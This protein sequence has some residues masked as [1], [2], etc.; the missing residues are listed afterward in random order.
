M[1]WPIWAIC[2]GPG[3]LRG[4]TDHSRNW[5]RC[6]GGAA[7][8]GGGQRGVAAHMPLLAATA[9]SAAPLLP[10]ACQRPA[11]LEPQLRMRPLPCARDM[12]RGA[13]SG[14]ACG[15]AVAVRAPS[16]RRACALAAGPPPA[17][18]RPA[19]KRRISGPQL[20]LME[21][22][23]VPAARKQQQQLRRGVA[24]SR[25][26]A[27]IGTP[28]RDAPTCSASRDA[29]APVPNEYSVK[30]SQEE[31]VK[32]GRPDHRPKS[33]AMAGS[34]RHAVHNVD[35]G[36][37]RGAGKAGAAGHA[38][39]R[40]AL[41]ALSRAAQCCTPLTVPPRSISCATPPG[42]ALHDDARAPEDGGGARGRPGAARGA[43]QGREHGPVGARLPRVRHRPW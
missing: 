8:R 21:G 43:D 4:L 38:R 31:G 27:V 34:A 25:I 11:F 40:Y 6:G 7:Q 16:A 36:V 42:A 2:K 10:R 12:G 41:R 32:A 13:S 33:T 29:A 20:W 15:A 19:G 3:S 39:R 24:S 37:R 18:R 26:P 17:H 28:F 35:C 5:E 22:G 1:A 30:Q 14:G 23:A 9:R